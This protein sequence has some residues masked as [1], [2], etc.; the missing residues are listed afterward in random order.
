[1]LEVRFLAGEGESMCVENCK[2]QNKQTET[3]CSKKSARGECSCSG[4]QPQR[5]GGVT[6]MNRSSKPVSPTE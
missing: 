2:K 1:M 6:G 4:L 5:S 3:P